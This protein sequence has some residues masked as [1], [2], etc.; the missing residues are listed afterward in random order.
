[1]P[2]VL[3]QILDAIHGETADFQ[4][5]A[6]IIRH[7]A[8][9]TTRLIAVAN[10]SYYGR[11]NRCTT[12]E[13]ALLYLGLEAVKTV[14]ITAAIKQFFNHFNSKHQ[15]FLRHFWRR[16]LISANFAKV[17]ATLTSYE[18]PEEAY[19]CG[20][21]SDVGQL[22][23]LTDHE[24]SYLPLLAKNFSD[25][26]LLKAEI[27][28]FQTSHCELG[29]ELIESWELSEFMADALRYHHETPEQVQDAHH[30]VKIVNL[31]NLLSAQ[32]RPTDQ[33][34]AAA[35]TLFGLTEALTLELNNRI[36]ND[37]Q[38]LAGSLGIDIE[39]DEQQA[40][41]QQQ[42][43]QRQ[44]GIKL[45]QFSEMA[46]MG[47]ELWQTD[48]NLAPFISRSLFLTFGIAN[49]QIFHFD[50]Q[51][52]TL[53]TELLDANDQPQRLSLALTAG[54][55]LLSDACLQNAPRNSQQYP[56]LTV[57]DRQLQHFFK[58]DIL[59]AWPLSCD[60]QPV[61]VVAM[62]VSREQLSSIER[63]QA[64]A[65]GLF[66]QIAKRL[67]SASAEQVATDSGLDDTELR[68]R[69]AIHEASNPL[70]IIRNYL[71]TLRHKLG[72]EHEATESLNLIREEIER[73]GNILL[74][75][76]DPE[77]ESEPGQPVAI[78]A[79]LEDII[80]LFR[81][82]LLASKQ[83]SVIM[84]LDNNV[85]MVEC[86]ASHLK[87]IITNLIKNAAEALDSSGQITI[88][89]EGGVSLGGKNYVAISVSD[90][91][92]GISDEIKQSL[93][94]PVSSTKGSGH[95][96]LGL[97]IVKKLLDE[98]GGQIVCRSNRNTGTEFQLLIP[99]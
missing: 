41:E 27:E 58:A 6:E 74:R 85:S 3:V 28:S 77:R 40:I 18:A 65:N 33:A 45:S 92:P 83:I 10:S 93:F 95:S 48:S 72:Q 21:L 68:I 9:V 22:M 15:N 29:G 5:I 87:Q 8:A 46:Q 81:E 43:A 52:Q 86:S 42:A 71:E 14:V 7:D 56:Q 50:P 53:N 75:L 84:Q 98:M 36:D 19:L 17:L 4:R 12:I 51:A 34:V 20:L 62:G 16:S 39:G 38:R 90:N 94:E 82:S 11:A 32:S 88:S 69:E 37:V 23:L 97:S 79:L 89:T 99:Q 70:S 91:G 47:N 25:Q 49:S 80:E 2:Q 1:M 64:L 78:N 73:V 60:Q 61:G 24:A 30:L 13:R 31:A 57:V 55:S 67:H 35:G 96:G 54:R 63:R 59:L 44:L 66:Q 76:R 26:Q